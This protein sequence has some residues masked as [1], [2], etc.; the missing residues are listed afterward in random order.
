MTTTH[1]RTCH[2]CEANC[3]VVITAEGREIIS[4]KGDPDNALSRG[5][6]CPKATALEDLQN[7]PDRLRRPQKRVGDHWED[8]SWEQAF[9]EIGARTREILARDP[10]STAI[11]VGNPNAHSY[12]NALT[13][14]DLRK[15]LR[16][17]N[18]F[19][20]STVDQMPHQVVN[21][22]LYGHS[23]LWAIPD[24]DN[25][26]TMIIMGGNPMASNGSV[27]TVPDFRNRAK[28]LQKRGGQ[29]VV[30]D[31]RRSETAKIADR[32][33]FIHPAT[34]AFMLVALLKALQSLVKP[35]APYVTN[36]D[37]LWSALAPFDAKACVARAGVTQADID[38]LA[39]RLT[40]GP[41][42]FYGRIGATTQTFG[43]LTAWLITCVNIVCGQLD[44]AGGLVFPSPAIDFTSIS[45]PGSIGRSRSRVSGHPEVLGEFPA[46]CL[47][48]EIET[49]GE[50][51][52]KALFVVAGNPVLSTPNGGRLDR[53][54]ATLD[55]MV[56]IDMYRN[57]TSRR[58]HYI[59][60]P[61][62]P[63]ERDHY[64]MFLLPIA[65]RN[66]AKY[67]NPM[68]ETAP[69][70]K[71]DWEI[72]RGL[73]SAISGQEVQ[74]PTPRET[75]DRLLQ[76]GPYKIS[77]AEVEAAPSGVDFGAPEPGR[78]PERLQS[79]DKTI[80]VAPGDF[81][82][83]LGRLAREMQAAPDARLKLIGRRHV[84]SNNTWLHNSPRLV[85]GKD[86]C[87]LLIHP[88]DARS[89]NLGDGSVAEVS[90]R[91]GAVRLKVEVTDDMM[92]GTVSIPHGWG[93]GLPG[94]S[95]ATASAHAGVSVNDLTDES[96]LDPL[97][98][99][100][101]LSGVPVEVRAVG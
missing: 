92:P 64:G 49:P 24:I 73:A 68:F 72:L 59:L 37:A 46:A 36:L 97:S 53:A 12:G 43:T 84:R 29:L 25:T 4:I 58:A 45:G 50:G 15:A 65:I 11:Y 47:S 54:L 57:A 7:D 63:L 38:W 41:A 5:H 98:G 79:K 42:A 55:L 71:Q 2:I 52:I 95:M 30:I 75:L 69:G 14:G 16:T 62:G 23:G 32:H 17:N 90:S 89:R 83:D 100:A 27:W 78:L 76:S 18:R 67:S 40:Q 31:P 70:E 56:S 96:M 88:D 94:I 1:N 21:L 20:A 81:V 13:S 86:R 34:D 82:A 6:I 101:A 26:E 99:N 61:V 85:K 3:G 22:R 60:P 39:Q 9:D 91:A 44:R 93:H 19:S 51:Q 35:V 87:T 74:G 66:F 10:K 48:E 8:I 33:I 28:A 77:L 80:N